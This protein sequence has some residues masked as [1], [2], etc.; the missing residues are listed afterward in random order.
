MLRVVGL[1]VRIGGCGVEPAAYEK[2]TLKRHACSVP[3]VNSQPLP[4]GFPLA[5]KSLPEGEAIENRNNIAGDFLIRNFQRELPDEGLEARIIAERGV[6][7]VDGD[8]DDGRR[9]LA[10]GALQPAD[11]ALPVA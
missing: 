5:S 9:M 2:G 3:G 7:G 11:G 1:Y 10:V 6:L 8:V 4:D